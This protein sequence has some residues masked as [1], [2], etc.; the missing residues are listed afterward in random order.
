MQ[1]R[2]DYEKQKWFILLF[3]DSL[4]GSVQKTDM[5]S[6]P[7]VFCSFVMWPL[8][9]SVSTINNTNVM[10]HLFRKKTFATNLFW[11]KYKS[12][13]L[14]C[15]SC[16]FIAS[17][18]TCVGNYELISV[19]TTKYENAKGCCTCTANAKRMSHSLRRLVIPESYKRFVHEQPITNIYLPSQHI[20]EAQARKLSMFYGCSY[21]YSIQMES[22]RSNAPIKTLNSLN[23]LI[24]EIIYSIFCVCFIQD[25]RDEQ[26]QP[27]AH[28]QTLSGHREPSRAAQEAA[29]DHH[30]GADGQLQ[31]AAL[32][33]PRWALRRALTEGAWWG[34]IYTYLRSHLR[35]HHHLFYRCCF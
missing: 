2:T 8:L 29:V 3:C 34:I 35:K 1:P 11:K 26:Q 18:G 13:V 17:L 33:K 7:L 5:I 9:G 21:R 24:N 25:H 14:F 22:L 30:A 10:L 4:I 6:S 32:G 23:Q 15:C 12:S 16:F 27:T 19:S 20:W 31:H 28:L